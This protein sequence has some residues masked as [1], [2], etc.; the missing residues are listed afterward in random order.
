VD[1]LL[2]SFRQITGDTSP[3]TEA[4]TGAVRMSQMRK[5][6][7]VA[8]IVIVTTQVVACARIDP[9]Q[10]R[11]NDVWSQRLTEQAQAQQQEAQRMERA[12]AAWSQRLTELAD[13]YRA[14]KAR[15]ERANAA[16][17]QRLTGLAEHLGVAGSTDR[18]NQAWT[19]RLNGL[20]E[21]YGV[22]D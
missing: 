8:L 4:M 18:A 6:Q 12:Q 7:A 5:F 16:Y 20:A 17:A 2:A 14:E 9:G 11:A 1:G 19:D 3:V 13:A 10:A 15:V 21:H 22:G